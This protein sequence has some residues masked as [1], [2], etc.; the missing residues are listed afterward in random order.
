MFKDEKEEINNKNDKHA[1]DN[2]YS[3][4]PFFWVLIIRKRQKANVFL[5]AMPVKVGA[6]AEF[7]FKALTLSMNPL[8]TLSWVRASKSIP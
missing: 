5:R 3:N 2:L 7:K 8:P 1:D 6:R 4:N